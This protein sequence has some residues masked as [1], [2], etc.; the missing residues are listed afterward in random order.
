MIT[1]DSLSKKYGKNTVVDDISFARQGRV[2]GFWARTAA[3]SPPRCDDGRAPR[4]RRDRHH[5]RSQVRGPP[6]PGARGRRDDRRLRP[7]RGPHRAGNPH[8]RPVDDG[9]SGVGSPRCWSWSAS[10]R[11]RR[12][13][14]W[15]TTPSDAPASRHR[16]RP[17]RRPHRAHPRRACQRARPG[18]DPVDED[19]LRASRTAAGPSCCPRTSS[20]RSRSSPTTS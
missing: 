14:G 17:D 9:T 19:L 11:A 10:P 5:L 18:R 2:T 8:D 20:T 3:A 1:I 7:A 4:R 6:Q 12:T 16:H 15:A 13:A